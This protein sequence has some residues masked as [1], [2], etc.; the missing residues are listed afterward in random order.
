LKIDQTS[1]Q[2]EFGT[3]S[4]APRWA[5]A[6]KFPPMQAA[7]RLRSVVVQVGRTGALTPVA[8]LDP[9]LLAGTTVSRASLHNEDEIGRL[10]LKIGDWV[11]V[12]K[13]GEIIPKV[14]KVLFDRRQEIEGELEEFQMPRTCPVCSAIVVRNDGE[15]VWRC[16]SSSCPAKL[17]N[18]LLL[19][20]SR[21]AMKIE[22]LGK[23]LVEQLVEKGLVKDL[24][25]LY[26]L[27]FDDIIGL[28]R[29]AKKSATNLLEQLQQSKTRELEKFVYGLGIPHVGARNAKILVNHFGS[30]DKLAEAS[31]VDLS[32]IPDIGKVMATEIYSWFHTAHNLTLLE[33]FRAV[34]F[35]LEV[36]SDGEKS[37]EKVLIGLQ[38]VLT[39]K[40]ESL[41]RDE[42]QKLIEMR[43]GRVTSS[44]S[45][46]TSYVVA[47]SDAGSKLDKAK[48]LGITILDE[49]AFLKLI[50]RDT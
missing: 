28:E 12:E 29:M 9:V 24:A 21:R 45:K 17:K 15:V 22:G 25:D 27:K 43:G 1:L 18:S 32:S 47:G 42:A 33:R 13:C 38:F 10:G 31:E 19:F 35:R 49:V 7:T 16:S 3:T 14:V 36:E 2:E 30:I 46:K 5:V 44:V 34:G 50:G 48:D 37:V 4:K 20:A 23:E 41:G 39:G 8:Q 11:V 26:Y 40:M 6:F